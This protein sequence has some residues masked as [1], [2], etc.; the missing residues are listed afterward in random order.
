[1]AMAEDDQ[2]RQILTWIGFT[3]QAERNA[4]V[5]D[6]MASY[7]DLLCLNT[8]DVTALSADF[9]RRTLAN[10]KI[11]FGS[12]RTKKL[13]SVLYWVKDFSRISETP[14]IGTLTENV[15]SIQLTRARHREEVRIQMIA[16]SDVKSKAASPGPL[17]SEST[18]PEWE[19]KFENY[20]AVIMGMNSV[21]LS[22][23]IREITSQIVLVLTQIL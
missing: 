15:F 14:T 1:M 20:L 17:V 6:A 4:I 19:P 23:V 12:R 13:Q 9:A 22:Y 21:P 3:I 10:G 8:K 11:V 7:D 2:I 16:Q 5:D 18:W